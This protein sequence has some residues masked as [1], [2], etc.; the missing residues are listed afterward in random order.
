MKPGISTCCN[1]D[2]ALC[3]ADLSDVPNRD[4]GDPCLVC[5]DL[6]DFPCEACGY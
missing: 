3:G 4:R 5:F 1:P 6:E 2:L